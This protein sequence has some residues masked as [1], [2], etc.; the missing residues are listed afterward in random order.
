MNYPKIKPNPC[1]I[2]EKEEGRIYCISTQQ[3]LGVGPGTNA[4]I[5]C[6]EHYSPSAFTKGGDEK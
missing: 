1:K 2:R 3:W 4:C 5:L 6:N